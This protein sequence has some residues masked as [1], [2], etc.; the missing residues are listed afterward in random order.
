MNIDLF[1]KKQEQIN[2]LEAQIREKNREIEFKNR[3][4][5][6]MRYKLGEANG[7][8][9]C[10][11]QNSKDVLKEKY[12]MLNVDGNTVM[13]YVAKVDTVKKSPLFTRSIIE[14]P[15]PQFHIPVKTQIEITF[16]GE[17]IK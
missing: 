1:Q 6:D 14:E 15:R 3:E 16:L 17:L 10:Y 8:V 2:R 7:K 13:C 9:K 4:I 12:H 5:A 11:E